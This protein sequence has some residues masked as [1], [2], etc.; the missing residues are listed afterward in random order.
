M[1]DL[2]RR[3]E[4]A[5]AA[6][7]PEPVC[8]REVGVRDALRA[9]LH[10]IGDPSVV[11]PIGTA[12]GS[13]TEIASTLRQVADDVE[14][15]RFVHVGLVAVRSD[16]GIATYYGGVSTQEAPFV[17]LG[18]IEWLRSRVLRGIED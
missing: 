11:V 6:T 17:L 5:L 14:H 9:L 2:I 15:G 13:R 12:D 16:G 4:E 3:A 10:E 1:R 8:E 18:G 7:A